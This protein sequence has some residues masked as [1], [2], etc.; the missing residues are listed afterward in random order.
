[1]EQAK[2]RILE[3]V[4]EL[5]SMVTIEVMIPQE[6]HRAIMGAKGSNVQEITTR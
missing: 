2:A 3:I 5:E 6:Y 4:K 1:M